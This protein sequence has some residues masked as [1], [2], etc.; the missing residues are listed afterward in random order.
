MYQAISSL[1]YIYGNVNDDPVLRRNKLR[2]AVNGPCSVKLHYA[3]FSNMYNFVHGP[4]YQLLL[5]VHCVSQSITDADLK[6]RCEG[7]SNS[8]LNSVGVD[9]QGGAITHNEAKTLEVIVATLRA[10]V[11]G[12]QDQDIGSNIHRD[13]V[14]AEVLELKE[15]YNGTSKNIQQRI[16][17]LLKVIDGMSEGLDKLLQLPRVSK[18][19]FDYK[20]LEILQ[21]CS[22]ALNSC[23]HGNAVNA[24]VKW[25]YNISAF[26]NHANDVAVLR[27][28][29]TQAYYSRKFYSLLSH[30]VMAVILNSYPTFSQMSNGGQ[31]PPS[32]HSSFLAAQQRNMLLSLLPMPAL[33][34]YGCL[35]RE[36]GFTLGLDAIDDGILRY[37]WSE[38]RLFVERIRREWDSAKSWEEDLAA[39][40][41]INVRRAGMDI[42]SLLPKQPNKT[43]TA[44]SLQQFLDVLKHVQGFVLEQSI[45]EPPL[46][47]ALGVVMYVVGF[48]SD[49]YW[50]AAPEFICTDSPVAARLTMSTLFVLGVCLLAA[51]KDAVFF[52]S[53]DE[54]ELMPVIAL[55]RLTAL[56]S[57]LVLGAM[58]A[59]PVLM[60]MLYIWDKTLGGLHDSAMHLPIN[61]LYEE[62]WELNGVLPG[63]LFFLAAVFLLKICLSAV[64]F[65]A[66]AGISFVS[67]LR[68]FKPDSGLTFSGLL[69]QFQVLIKALF[70]VCILSLVLTPFCINEHSGHTYLPMVT[71]SLSFLVAVGMILGI[72]KLGGGGSLMHSFF[73]AVLQFSADLLYGS[74]FALTDFPYQLQLTAAVYLA[75]TGSRKGQEPGIIP[76]CGLF[77]LLQVFGTLELSK[78]DYHKTPVVIGYWLYM[79][80][81]PLSLYGYRST[82]GTSFIAGSISQQDTLSS[83]AKHEIQ[84]AS[85]A[86]LQRTHYLLVLSEV[87]R[88]VLVKCPCCC[89]GV[90]ALLNKD[91]AAEDGLGEALIN[92]DEAFQS[93]REVV[94]TSS[95]SLVSNALHRPISYDRSDQGSNE[96]VRDHS[97][98]SGESIV[99]LFDGHRIH[100]LAI[101]YYNDNPRKLDDLVGNV[102]QPVPVSL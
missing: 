91:F 78:M 67:A 36:G 74:Y 42:T 63:I 41:M 22:K 16:L 83:F 93:S 28:M 98:T 39:G 80:L 92:E 66:K 87:L 75:G 13:S 35:L 70:C 100:E 60:S 46:L 11:L 79:F 86:R 54:N 73:N 71:S 40:Y 65:Y 26:K 43:M 6:S 69:Q 17:E 102:R 76:V 53:L 32:S 81:K 38:V 55:A 62:A 51:F 1:E 25:L 4:F 7:F 8:L 97:I 64:L 58:I 84:A 50:D 90:L 21:S 88:Q 33:V 72:P 96:F 5:V 57:N 10:C 37:C 47:A 68:N 82:S 85:K 30:L 2:A 9:Y 89:A 14:I 48:V 3:W 56:G 49:D 23:K 99:G 52:V 20:Y 95:S 44:D 29:Y 61:K 45:M 59:N 18:G 12:C 15:I 101:K 77:V 19:V 31:R 27:K 34:T 94:S 24:D